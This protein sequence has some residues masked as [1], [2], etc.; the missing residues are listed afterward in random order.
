MRSSNCLSKSR[1]SNRREVCILTVKWTYNSNQFD[2][3]ETMVNPLGGHYKQGN[4]M[5]SALNFH[6]LLC[7]MSKL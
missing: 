4:C 6:S 3:R 7:L 2:A 1:I 5:L